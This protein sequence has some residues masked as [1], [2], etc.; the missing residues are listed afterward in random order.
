MQNILVAT[1]FSTNADAA[2]RY[3]WH[4]VLPFARKFVLFNAQEEGHLAK[5]AEHELSARQKSLQV[6]NPNHIEITTYLSTKS[7]TEGLLEAIQTEAID[8]VFVGMRGLSTIE[9]ILI[10]SSAVK[11]L[12]EIEQP[13]FVIPPN[14]SFTEIDKIL[15]ANDLSKKYTQNTLAP[16]M[17]V[18]RQYTATVRL[19][20]IRL[21]GEQTN[22]EEEEINRKRLANYFEIEQVSYAFK[23]VVSESVIEGL[24]YYIG[25][26]ADHDMLVMVTHKRN[27]FEKLFGISYSNQ[28]A[29]Q[30]VMPMLVLKE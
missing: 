18:A 12:N 17:L 23:T 27:W 24:L 5:A 28:L 4:L 20:N 14:M 29:T 9:E 7:L 1:D 10:G 30:A 11:I 13:I 21:R 6:L 19:V 3:A 22:S 25:Y 8:A 26:K 15:F 16:L 2:M